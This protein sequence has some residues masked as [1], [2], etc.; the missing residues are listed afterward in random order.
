MLNHKSKSFIPIF[1]YYLMNKQQLIQSLKERGFSK[2]ILDAFAKVKRENFIPE[3][4]RDMAYEDT[5][6]PIGKGQTISQP[7]T[8]AKMFSL[9]DLKE[10]QKVL[11]IGSGCGYALA[12]LSEIAGKDGEVYG[13]EIVKEL[14]ERSKKNLKDYDNIKVY[15]GNGADGIPEHAPFD[16]IL[17]SAGCREIPDEVF[18]QLK[19]NGII[20]APIGPGQELALVSIRKINGKKTIVERI[21]G[22]VF[23]PF[24][25]D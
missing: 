9:L 7:Y 23:V 21:P 1:L 18:S 4:S 16:R 14:A 10:E 17:I 3:E 24:V 11:E 15:H 5:A 19:E 2:Q 22:F 20:V 6:L 25:E 8:I 13:I 12:L